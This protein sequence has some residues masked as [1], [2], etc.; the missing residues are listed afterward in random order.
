MYESRCG[1]C[2]NQCERKEEV[3]CKGCLEMKTTFWGGNCGVKSCC[4][5]KKLNHCGECGDFPCEML[6]TMGVELG[7]DPAPR[8]ANCKKWASGSHS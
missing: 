1:I 2:C 5:T 6:A 4:E 7:Y 8:L 3:D